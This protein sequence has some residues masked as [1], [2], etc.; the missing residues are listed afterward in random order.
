MSDIGPDEKD[1]S[2]RAKESKEKSA[3]CEEDKEVKEKSAA[4]HGFSLLFG[5]DALII[6]QMMIANFRIS[7]L[8][9][10]YAHMLVFS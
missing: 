9:F 3:A 1:K 7:V 10:Y 5:T 8:F 6:R 4:E 2:A